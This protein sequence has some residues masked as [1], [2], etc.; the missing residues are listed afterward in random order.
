MKFFPHLCRLPHV[1]L[2]ILGI[3]FRVVVVHNT[4]IMKGI[5]LAGGTGSRLFPLTKATSKQ[6]L[7]IYNKPMIYYP[8]ETLIAAGITEILI[9]VAPDY[10]GDFL[11]LLGSGR[12]FGAK[13]TYEIQ[14]EP[15]GLAEAFIIGET[16]IGADDV[17]MVLGDNYFDEDFSA[18]VQTFTG[19]GRIFCKEVPD[20][21]RYGIATFNE[22]GEVTRI[23]EKPKNPDSSFAIAG[24]YMFDNSCI[25]KAKQVKPSARGEIEITEIHQQYMDEGSLDIAFIEG[26][27]LDTGTF[28]TWFEATAYVR[29]KELSSKKLRS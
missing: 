7:P 24:I 4:I 5:I 25:D 8:I 12:Q 22:Q 14:D 21:E 11:R 26:A 2:A 10:A 27:W 18:Y 9:I 20:P 6:L 13:F 1:Y 28:E 17:C 29:E 15:K 16:F 19:G 23:E 3:F